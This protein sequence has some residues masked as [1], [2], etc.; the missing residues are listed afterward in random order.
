M[1]LKLLAVAII[2]VIVSILM[3]RDVRN[4][5]V[6]S[7]YLRAGLDTPFGSL[8]APQEQSGLCSGAPTTGNT[9]SRLMLLQKEDQVPASQ[10]SDQPG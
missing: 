7:C 5:T 4:E 9:S 2:L 8:G 3:I 10:L 1:K 6:S